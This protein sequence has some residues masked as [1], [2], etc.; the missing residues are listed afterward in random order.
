M[1]ASIRPQTAGA[2]PYVPSDR[3]CPPARRAC[4]RLSSARSALSAFPLQGTGKVYE[5]YIVALC[6]LVT[7]GN[8][9]K[10]L[11]RCKLGAR[12]AGGAPRRRRRAH[13]ASALGCQRVGTGARDR[14][15]RGALHISSRSGELF[16][17]ETKGESFA[18]D[19]RASSIRRRVHNPVTHEWLDT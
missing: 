15:S 6:L 18:C 13:R 3:S 4:F 7:R 16:G 10:L 11:R 19:D 8:W 1:S 2:P 12:A 9:R 5:G 17:L 14:S